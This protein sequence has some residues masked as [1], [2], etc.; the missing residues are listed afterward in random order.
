MIENLDLKGLAS[1]L[2]T[3]ITLQVVIGVIVI[4]NLIATVFKGE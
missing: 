1:V 4:A 2:S 3:I